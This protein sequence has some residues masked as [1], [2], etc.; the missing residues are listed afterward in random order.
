MA[1]PSRI[2]S[3]RR[4]AAV[5]TFGARLSRPRLL[6]ALWLLEEHFQGSTMSTL[7]AFINRVAD[8]NGYE[9]EQR[10]QLY[11][12]FYSHLTRPDS[13]LPADPVDEMHLHPPDRLESMLGETAPDAAAGTGPIH[14]AQGP[15]HAPVQ[16]AAPPPPAPPPPA[17]GTVV[18]RTLTEG[19]R[20]ALRRRDGGQM[21]AFRQ[22]LAQ[23]LEES[24]L[25]LGTMD[26][27]RRWSEDGGALPDGIGR[28][29]MAAVVLLLYVVLCELLGPVSADEMLYRTVE[30]VDQLPE[31]VEFPPRNLL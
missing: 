5:A 26:A 27:V 23:K 18:F 9:R 2:L 1:D 30:R 29:E 20:D 16:R 17:A 8:L 15:R 3:R 19:L 6:Q 11:I 21:L 4:R 12:E 10:R 31:A 25:S 7:I 24:G 13:E 14:A 22:R 28:D